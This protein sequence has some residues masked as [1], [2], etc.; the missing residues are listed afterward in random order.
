[1]KMRWKRERD[2][3]EA[4]LRGARPTASD[5]LVGEL[6]ERVLATKV[7]R[8]GHGS[9]FAFAAALTVFMLGTFASF[10]GLSHAASSAQTTASAVKRIVAP[11]KAQKRT[12]RSS[13]STQYGE[14]SVLTPPVA[15]SKKPKPTVQVAAATAAGDPPQ[16]G[17]LPFTGY[18]LGMTAAIG[19]LLLALGVYL[20]R[21]ESRE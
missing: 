10:G 13:A 15:K 1:M 16:S 17:T 20:R 9:R 6:G 12:H 14:Q 2:S 21:R 7:P 19:S 4:A 11:A 8:S 18:G 5:E 3:V